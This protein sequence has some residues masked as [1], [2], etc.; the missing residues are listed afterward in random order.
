ME[1][2]DLEETRENMN[3]YFIAINIGR[4]ANNGNV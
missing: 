1:S 2:K 3:E 4:I